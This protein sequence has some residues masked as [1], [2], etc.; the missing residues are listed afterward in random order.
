MKPSSGLSVNFIKVFE[1][2]YS[3][4]RFIL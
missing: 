1:R 2:K 3:Y 4:L